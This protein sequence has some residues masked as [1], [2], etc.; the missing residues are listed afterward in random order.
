MTDLDLVAE[1]P[2]R[3]SQSLYS[4]RSADPW[5]VEARATARD[6]VA[7]RRS[8]RVRMLLRSLCL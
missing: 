2:V 1:Q 4:R 7:R 3:L 8:G 6:D 5:P